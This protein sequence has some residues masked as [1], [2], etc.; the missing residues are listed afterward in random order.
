VAAVVGEP[1][2]VFGVAVEI[3]GQIIAERDGGGDEDATQ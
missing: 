2:H 3:E 1:A